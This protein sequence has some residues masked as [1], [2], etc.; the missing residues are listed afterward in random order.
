MVGSEQLDRL[1]IGSPHL[2]Q[3]GFSF[4]SDIH[5]SQFQVSTVKITQSVNYGFHVFGGRN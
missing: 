5:Y 3:H 4:S 1:D 2:G